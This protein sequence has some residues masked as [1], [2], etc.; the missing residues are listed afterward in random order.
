MTRRGFTLIELLVVIAIIAILAA[1]LFPVF[2]KAREKARQSS[3]ASNLKQ[4]SLGWLSY[5]QDYD[6]RTPPMGASPDDP[7]SPDYIWWHDRVMPYIKNKQVFECPSAD[8]FA[9]LN[10]GCN[11]GGWSGGYF[12]TCAVW[13]TPAKIGT[14]EFPSEVVSIAELHYATCNRRGAGYC[15]WGRADDRATKRHNDGTNAAYIDG[16]VKWSKEEASAAAW[17][18]YHPTLQP[19]T[20]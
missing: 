1:I 12:G 3:C 17:K 9:D 5:I 8:G 16:H 7:N 15:W 18:K 2:A 11:S 13:W 10:N 20:S 6:E 4:L 14:F 19:R